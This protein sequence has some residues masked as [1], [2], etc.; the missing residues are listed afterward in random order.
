MR[1][2]QFKGPFTNGQSIE[3]NPP[4]T[5]YDEDV[6]FLIRHIGV[7]IPNRKQPFF[8]APEGSTITF[9]LSPDFYINRSTNSYRV[10]QTGLLEFDDLSLEKCTIYI[11]RNLG[12]NALIDIGYEP[13]ED[14]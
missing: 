6:R 13:K 3:V 4:I 9:D 8:I 12:S 5:G 11:Q 1:Y 2:L 10:N 7:Q 14:E